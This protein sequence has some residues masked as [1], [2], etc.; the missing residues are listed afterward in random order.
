MRRDKK[1]NS[2]IKETLKMSLINNFTSNNML[3]SVYGA[4][5]MFIVRVWFHAFGQE[6]H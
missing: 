2:C 1:S 5:G 4:V 6:S 3:G